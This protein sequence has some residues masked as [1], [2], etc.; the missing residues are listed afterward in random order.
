M[1]N[2]STIT[3]DVTH[4][5]AAAS[6]WEIV[7]SLT[8]PANQSMSAFFDCTVKGSAGGTQSEFA[9]FTCDSFTGGSSS[10]VT[11]NKVDPSDPETPQGNWKS[12]GAGGGQPTPVNPVQVDKIV[13]GTLQSGP[14]RVRKVRGGKT[15]YIA[16][17]NATSSTQAIVVGNCNQ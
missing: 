1:S 2:L 4:T 11:Q 15:I 16:H 6:A 8:A 7:L 17:K 3:D 12:W 5:A 14:T 10:A 9:V 13:L